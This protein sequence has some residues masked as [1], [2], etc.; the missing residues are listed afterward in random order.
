[1]LRLITQRL[2]MSL[3]VL[4][5]V[6]VIIFAMI[7]LLPGDAAT[8]YLGRNATPEGLARVRADLGLERPAPERFVAWVGDLL[9]ADLGVSLSRQESVA[10]VVW[11][12]LRNSLLLGLSAAAIGVPLALTL[13]VVAGLTQDRW[14]DMIIATFSLVGMS[15]PEFV[16]GT[17]LI[18]LFSLQLNLFP[19][20]TIANPDASLSELLPNIVLPMLSLLVLLTGYYLRIVRTSIINVM[21]SEY[22]LM[23]RLNGLPFMRVVLRH[24]LPNA[25]LPAIAALAL[26]MAWLIGNLFVIESIFNYPGIGRLMITAIHDRA[27]PLV[28]GI[29]I[30]LAAIYVLVNLMADVL[31]LILNPRLRTMHR[32]AG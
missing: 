14:P 2:A 12:R 29:A 19:A 25:L 9:R 3:L 18:Y 11:M 31:T 4:A 21:Q 22:V 23:A 26:L 1:M 10:N 7:E 15:L 5:L 8:A 24:A 30:V 27:L 32:G 17:L 28:Q 6:S 16:T 20:V 13:G